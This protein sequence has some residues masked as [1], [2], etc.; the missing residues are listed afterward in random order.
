MLPKNDLS[1]MLLLSPESC[2]P[3]TTTSNKN[4]TRLQQLWWTNDTNKNE[5]F[6]CSFHHFTASYI[7]LLLSWFITVFGMYHHLFP[8]YFLILLNTFITHEE[9]QLFSFLVL[10]LSCWAL[11][12]PVRYLWSSH[13][14]RVST[15]V[16]CGVQQVALPDRRDWL[17]R[18]PAGARRGTVLVGS[19][20]A[21]RKT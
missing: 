11:I 19:K 5:W 7:R 18:P 17:T 12:V 21:R 3:T 1:H 4:A 9:R 6:W 16:F 2:T 15:G 13:G 20:I 8:K 10:I 14:V